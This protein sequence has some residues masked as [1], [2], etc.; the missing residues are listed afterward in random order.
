[1]FRTV[2]KEERDDRALFQLM[3]D[4]VL[5]LDDIESVSQLQYHKAYIVGL[6]NAKEHTDQED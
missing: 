4:G 1:V 6:K 5:T 2:V 3:Q